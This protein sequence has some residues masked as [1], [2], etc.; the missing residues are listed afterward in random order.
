MVGKNVCHGFVFDQSDASS[1]PNGK[2]A[3]LDLMINGLKVYC[4]KK[5]QG[6][7]MHDILAAL[8]LLNPEY[9]QW[10]DGE[11]FRENGSWGFRSGGSIKALVGVD[12]KA[13]INSLAY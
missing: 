8:M 11:P 1:L 6:K 9:G 5:P 12:K 10:I 3:G 2:H 7:A 13:V 4:K